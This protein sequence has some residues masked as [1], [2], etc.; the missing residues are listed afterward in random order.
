L[1][2]PGFHS[3]TVPATYRKL[4]KALNNSWLAGTPAVLGKKLDE[5]HHIEYALHTFLDRHVLALLRK[6][7][8][9]SGLTVEMGHV[10]LTLQS[11]ELELRVPQLSSEPSV[12]SFR[13]IEDVIMIHSTPTGF[14]PMLSPEQR[15]AWDT[16]LRGVNA[17]GAA[18]VLED[19]EAW[20]K[21]WQQ[22][23]T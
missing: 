9:W 3:G 2:R 21:F 7:K 4:R 15:E 12:L 17:W 16:A 5:L 19:Y 10:Q 13:R 18:G 1:L 20:V 14:V 23:T 8:A 11:M 22:Q 6:S